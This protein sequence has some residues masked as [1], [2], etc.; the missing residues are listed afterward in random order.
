MP[1][2]MSSYSGSVRSRSAFL[3]RKS[4][5]REFVLR[6]VV[7]KAHPGVRWGRVGVPVVLL[8]ILA[9][10][11]LVLSRPNRRSLRIGS[12]PFHNDSE[13]AGVLQQIAQARQAV[14]VPAEDPGVGVFE[15]EVLPG[16]AV[17]G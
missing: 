13:K 9:V 10:I 12:L 8:D 4:S 7:A 15:G 3:V 1:V 11:A 5:L 17:R 6:V 14:L 16:I 2:S